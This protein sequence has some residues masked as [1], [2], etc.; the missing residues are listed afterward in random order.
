MKHRSNC[1]LFSR[2]I[3][4]LALQV[5]CVASTQAQP[6]KMIG[7]WNVK[8]TLANANEY[9]LRFDAQPDGKG[10]LLLVDP[11]LWDGAKPS[12]AKWSQGDGDSVTFS[13]NVE[14]AL[15]NVGRDAG[16]L[17]FRGK[18]GTDAS[19]TGEAEFSPLAGEGPSKHGTFKAV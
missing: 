10:S 2:I 4:I 18:L 12:E 15:G 7:K 5:C 13:G 8:F 17:I 16:I 11:R 14:F 6:P 3:L 19:M 9:S 1:L